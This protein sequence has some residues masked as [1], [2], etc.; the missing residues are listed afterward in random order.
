MPKAQ[1]DPC[2]LPVLTGK[3]KYENQKNFV[4]ELFFIAGLAVLT[5]L[6]LIS[7]EGCE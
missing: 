6:S 7:I 3:D 1:K 4:E 5:F 2:L